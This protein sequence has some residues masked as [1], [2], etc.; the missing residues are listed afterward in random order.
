[1]TLACLIIA[2]AWAASTD[3]SRETFWVLAR[4]AVWP[5]AL[6]VLHTAVRFLAEFSRWG[7]ERKYWRH[8]PPGAA[9]FS[10]RL[11]DPPEPSGGPEHLPTDPPTISY[12]VLGQPQ[13]PIPRL[14]S[15]EW[16][17]LNLRRACLSFLDGGHAIGD[18]WGFREMK[19]AGLIEREGWDECVRALRGAG[20]LTSF[21]GLGTHPQPDYPGALER[22]RRGAPLPYSDGPIPQVAR[23]HNTAQLA[24]AGTANTGAA[25]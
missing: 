10:L 7:W 21:P 23:L 6:P 20:L 3:N 16:R 8:R 4:F 2:G 11:P 13:P 9:G 18:C 17:D 15:G 25:G 14:S 24:G 5:L 1:M 19:A 22:L 12:N